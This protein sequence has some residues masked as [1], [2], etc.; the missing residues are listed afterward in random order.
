MEVLPVEWL[1][2]PFIPLCKVTILQGDPGMGKTFLATRIAAI[3]S[4]GEG[5][6]YMESSTGNTSPANVLFQTAED[7]LGDTIKYD[8][9]TRAR[10]VPGSL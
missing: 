3:V 5:F 2:K 7:G 9:W 6:P 10:T 1:W 4:R 8:L